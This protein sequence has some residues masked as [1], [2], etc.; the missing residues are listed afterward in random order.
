[1]LI[2]I[3]EGAKATLAADIIL[4]V[5][6]A[7]DPHTVADLDLKAVVLT[8][9]EEGLA[10]GLLI[11]REESTITV[12]ILDMLPH[13]DRDHRLTIDVGH[14]VEALVLLVLVT[15][16]G[17]KVSMVGTIEDTM[18]HVFE[19][20]VEEG[21]L[22]GVVDEGEEEEDMS[23]A[24]VLNPIPILETIVRILISMIR[25]KMCK[26]QILLILAKK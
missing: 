11:T 14:E 13:L 26:A 10:Q 18:E 1:M 22:E 20:V 21:A 23:H 6:V 3:L 17:E 2:T 15:Q 7:A 24:E 4:Q 8:E 9:V 19:D 16:G 12:V 25:V 5:K